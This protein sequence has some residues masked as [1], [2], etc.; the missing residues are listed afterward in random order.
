LQRN[1]D[2]VKRKYNNLDVRYKEAKRQNQTLKN[3]IRKKS[4]Q[5]RE[6][7]EWWSSQKQKVKTKGSVS[8]PKPQTVNPESQAEQSRPGLPGKLDIGRYPEFDYLNEDEDEVDE[9]DFIH[10]TFDPDA[11]A[12]R[13]ETQPASPL[14]EKDRYSLASLRGLDI[15]P[16]GFDIF[17]KRAQPRIH[18]PNTPVAPQSGNEDDIK[19]TIRNA[20]LSARKSVPPSASKTREV[21][22]LLD[23]PEKVVSKLG[24][25]PVGIS[26]ASSLS[27]SPAP[28]PKSAPAQQTRASKLSAP[29]SARPAQRKKKVREY[30][31]MRHWTEDGTDGIK[32]LPPSPVEDDTGLLTAMLEGPPPGPPGIASPLPLPQRKVV[33]STPEH[34]TSENVS[35]VKTGRVRDLLET[36]GESGAGYVSSDGREVKRQ[37]GN[38]TMSEPRSRRRILSPDLASKNKGRGRYAASVVK[39]Y[40]PR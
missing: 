35:V 39:R 12:S 14:E 25:I 8:P 29:L 16:K 23:S 19:K 40:S 3:D 37:K 28:R 18:K 21:I 7:Y 38:R 1:F 6:W 9:A 27:L 10:T 2:T 17:D 20:N 24:T 32:P 34:T 5:W 11:V 31:S 22:D 30:P 36:E 15:P 4:D 13:R 26:P 33:P